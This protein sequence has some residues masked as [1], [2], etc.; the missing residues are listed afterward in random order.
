[1]CN[2]MRD[3][4]RVGIRD[5]VLERIGELTPKNSIHRAYAEA[6]SQ[7]AR[8]AGEDRIGLLVEQAHEASV[9]DA[10][11]AA[12]MS[13]VHTQ[14]NHIMDILQNEGRAALKAELDR[15]GIDYSNDAPELS[16]SRLSLEMV[17][18]SSGG[19]MSIDGP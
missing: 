4:E 15:N 13:V 14:Q 11:D 12:A 5:P 17:A 18:G 19:G 10:I 9:A 6:I 3:Q 7:R 1:M 8:E 16:A 2:V